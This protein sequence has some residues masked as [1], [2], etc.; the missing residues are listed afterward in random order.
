MAVLKILCL[1]RVLGLQHLGF[2]RLQHVTETAP[3]R[4]RPDDL[5]ELALLERA[6]KQICERPEEAD[7]EIEGGCV[8]HR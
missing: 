1:H 8:V 4:K 5:L 3:H 6:M 7:D 2:R